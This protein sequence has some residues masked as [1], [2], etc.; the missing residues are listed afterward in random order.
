MVTKMKRDGFTTINGEHLSRW[1]WCYKIGIELTQSN[2]IVIVLLVNGI[3]E[4]KNL[5]TALMPSHVNPRFLP[6]ENNI[7]SAHFL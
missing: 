3:L 6:L 5:F 7:A 4:A 1:C 2:V